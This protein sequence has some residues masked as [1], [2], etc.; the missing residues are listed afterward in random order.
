MYVYVLVFYVI[1]HSLQDMR[2]RDEQSEV[3]LWAS[4]EGCLEDVI[5][6]LSSGVEVN[7]RGQVRPALISE[8]LLN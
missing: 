2:H 8:F 3:L 4:G 7:S 6:L 1:A 5:L